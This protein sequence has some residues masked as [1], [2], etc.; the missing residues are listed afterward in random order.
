MKRAGMQKRSLFAGL[1]LAAFC[2]IVQSQGE[3]MIGLNVLYRLK[4]GTRD[5]FLRAAGRAGIVESCRKEPG[6]AGYGYFLSVDNPDEALVVER[7]VD[8]QS[9]KA[10]LEGP[11]PKV[12]GP[13]K[14]QFLLEMIPQKFSL[15]EEK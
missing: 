12:L 11:V 2:A 10:H 15:P 9:F 3:D 7:W 5:E 4:K 14:E 8:E 1:V 13:I 6:N